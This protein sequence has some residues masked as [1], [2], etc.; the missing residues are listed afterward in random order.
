MA[1]YNH[2]RLFSQMMRTALEGS[3]TFESI[4]AYYVKFENSEN[5]IPGRFR[6]RVSDVSNREFVQTLNPDVDPEYIPE[7]STLTGQLDKWSEN[8]WIPCLDWMGDHELSTID[9]IEKDLVEKFEMFT[10]GSSGASGSWEESPKKPESP[11]KQISEPSKKEESKKEIKN[12]ADDDIDW[13]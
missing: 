9:S 12:S 1:T 5:S 8:G 3:E 4:W 6:I 13:L 2:K 11:K 10:I 7:G